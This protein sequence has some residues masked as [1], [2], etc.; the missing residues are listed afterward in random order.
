MNKIICDVCGTDY[1]ETAA[2]CPICGCASAGA[3]TSAGNE[4]ADAEEQAAYVPVKGGRFSK[5]NVRKRLKNSQMYYDP[6][7]EPDPE[8][9]YED[10]QDPEEEDA[11]EDHG[12]NRGLLI[13]VAILLLAIVAV[14]IYIGV[15]IF[16]VGS[17]DPVSVGKPGTSQSTST[18]PTTEPVTDPTTTAKVHCEALQLSSLEIDRLQVGTEWL[19]MV[20]KVPEQTTE[21][22]RFETSDPNVATVSEDGRIRAIG[23]GEAIITVTCGE[24][25][26]TVKVVC[27]AETTDTTDP[28]D[29]TDPTETTD[30]TD[31]TENTEPSEVPSDFVLKLNRKDFT[32]NKAGDTHNLYNGDVDASEITWESLDETVVTVKD[33]VVTAVGKG[34]T[35]VVAKYGDQKVSCWVSSN[36]KKAQETEPAG[37][38]GAESGD[39]AAATYKLL[40]NGKICKD[41]DQYNGDVSLPIGD[42]FSLT[43]V[44]EDGKQQDVTWK[45]SKEGVCSVNGRTVTGESAGT[46]N[47][48]VTIDGQTYKC[49]VRVNAS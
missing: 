10:D 40:V 24:V 9:E 6:I 47:L 46:V 4:V 27:V 45:M 26:E 43:I 8:P 11:E 32:L 48:T 2:Q 35:Q 14:S 12:S 23:A 1:P 39:G 16:G 13:V 19:L 42:N 17:D 7:P 18:N 20:T 34:R 22:V 49:I 28:T 41:G 37:P 5:A 21:D 25:T 36:A 38:N 3:Q 29:P 30:P 44:D 33:G 15:E 31:P